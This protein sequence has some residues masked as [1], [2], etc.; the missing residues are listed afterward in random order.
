MLQNAIKKHEFNKFNLFHIG[1]I[2]NT[3]LIL[4]PKFSLNFLL[5]MEYLPLL[6]CYLY[7]PLI[8]DIF[9]NLLSPNSSKFVIEESYQMEIWKNC[10]NNNIFF[11]LSK[12]ILRGGEISHCHHSN[13]DISSYSFPLKYEK[14][15]RN[16]SHSTESLKIELDKIFGKNSYFENSPL[17]IQVIYLNKKKNLY[18]IIIS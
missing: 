4:E 7:N 14:N 13:I 11:D 3:F 16:S 2:L 1:K 10:Y 9:L 17:I 8:F 18:I 6:S 15:M 12:Q 5:E